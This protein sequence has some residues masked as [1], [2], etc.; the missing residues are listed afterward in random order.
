MSQRRASEERRDETGA[1]RVAVLAANVGQ[2][3]SF[4]WS[5][6]G[7]KWVAWKGSV[8]DRNETQLLIKY[9]E[10]TPE[11]AHEKVTFPPA[12]RI[13]LRKPS[14]AD[15]VL[16]DEPPTVDEPWSEKFVSFKRPRSA[17]ETHEVVEVDDDDELFAK[18]CRTE[19]K[20]QHLTV[21]EELGALS[22]GTYV[23]KFAKGSDEFIATGSVEG[24]LLHLVDGRKLD[25]KKL[26]VQGWKVKSISSEEEDEDVTQ[27]L[28][29][30]E[31][32]FTLPKV[33]E[34]FK[35]NGF[36]GLKTMLRDTYQV[37]Q[38][39]PT[40]ARYREV[41]RLCIWCRENTKPSQLGRRCLQDVQISALVAVGH[42][43]AQ[44][45]A[46]LLKDEVGSNTFLKLMASQTGK[47]KQPF[48]PQFRQ[49][50]PFFRQQ[51]N[52]EQQKPEHAELQS[53]SQCTFC[54]RVGH[55][56]SQCWAKFGK[57]PRR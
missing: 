48:R 8:V 12:K 46:K 57:P 13:F 26:L 49:N 47:T 22:A 51:P 38:N 3:V 28:G 34:Y 44:A 7:T 5:A 4:E 50:R 19:N 54:K 33:M 35:K 1:T 20:G 10:G 43:G 17:T 39:S 45:R 6:D 14:I 55:S 40:D 36:Q 23:I 56:E 18:M 32:V 27:G 21:G 2:V 53:P 29:D 9:P 24:D 11:C 16:S 31:H 37:A 25:W 42:S 15:A 30:A 52:T 41:E